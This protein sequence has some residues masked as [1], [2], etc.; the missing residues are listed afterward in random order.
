MKSAK[1]FLFSRESRKADTVLNVA[2]I[3]IGGRDIVVAAGPCAVESEGQLLETARA[4]R[5][6][7]AAVLRGGAYTPRSSPYS[8]QVLEEKGMEI[9]KTVKEKTGMPVVTEIMSIEDAKRYAGMVD[10][11]QVGARNAQNFSLLKCLGA[12]GAPVFLKNGIGN[13]TEEW[14][15]ASEYILS[16]G[17]RNVI[18]CYRGIRTIE[19]GTRFAMDVGAIASVKR[20]SHLPVAADPSHAAGNRNYVA[21]LAFAAVAAG[22]DMLEIEVHPDPENALSDREQQLDFGEFGELM[23]GLD[24]VAKALGRRIYRLGD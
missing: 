24:A 20:R 17:N 12:L 8:F 22:A 7:G 11:M 19:T 18:L 16:G 23:H 10:I 6:A 5:R 1:D 13:T 9:L 4:V 14:L 15:M 21:A 2:G 3:P